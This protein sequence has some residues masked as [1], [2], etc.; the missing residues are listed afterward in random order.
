[1]KECTSEWRRRMG[2]RK[3]E[4]ATIS[5]KFSFLLCLDKAKYYW[6]KNEA[7]SINFDGCHSSPKSLPQ[8]RSQGSFLPA[9]R[10]GENPGN[11]VAITVHL[12]T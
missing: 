9:L 3:G 4:L 1:M 6:L 8:P 11:E 10:V 5:Y 2:R 12:E 7:P